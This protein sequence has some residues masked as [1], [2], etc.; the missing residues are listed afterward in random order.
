M[1]VESIKEAIAELDA[2]QKA[3]LTACLVEQ[4]GAEWDRQI[5]EAR[6]DV[7]ASSKGDS[8]SGAQIAKSPPS[9]AGL[10]PLA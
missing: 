9:R 2:E 5:E 1:T 8:I 3:L 6:S 4:D 7:R 10:Y